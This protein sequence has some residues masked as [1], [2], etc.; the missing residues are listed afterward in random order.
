MEYL[1]EIARRAENDIEKLEGVVE[2]DPSRA[3]IEGPSMVIEDL[4]DPRDSK[5]L[6]RHY[7]RRLLDRGFAPKR[8]F[9]DTT[10]GTS[11]MSI[12][13]FQAAEELG[14]SSIYVMGLMDD[15]ER[16]GLILDPE[17][18]A[19]AEPRFMSNHTG[20]PA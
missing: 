2:L 12:G 6:V 7:L 17:D 8:I 1:L 9:V 10:A 16:K 14:I 4:L 19:Q 15:G 3:E 11:P 18:P 13:A 5:R 20:E